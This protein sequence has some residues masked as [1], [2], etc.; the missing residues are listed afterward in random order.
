MHLTLAAPIA[1]ALA[2]RVLPPTVVEEGV[3]SNVEAGD[4]LGPWPHVALAYANGDG[5]APDL[6]VLG[7]EPV[8]AT[9]EVIVRARMRREAGLYTWDVLERVPLRASK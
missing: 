7:I 6:E 1:R 3:V 9:V 2:V 4:A 5:P 8:T